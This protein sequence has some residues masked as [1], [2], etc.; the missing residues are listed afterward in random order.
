MKT[1]KWTAGLGVA[2][3]AA[4]CSGGN[5]GDTAPLAVHLKVSGPS[6]SFAA[7]T[8]G[9]TLSSALMV[10]REFELDQTEDADEALDVERGPYLVD[11]TA[12]DFNGTIQQS[13][14][15]TS[16][17]VGVYDEVE[18]EIHKLD[19]S[20][21]DDVAAANAD[22]AGLGAMLSAGLS[23]KIAGMSSAGTQFVFESSLNE[24]QE[25]AVNVV[26]GDAVS[27]IDGVTLTIDPQIWFRHPDTGACLDPLDAANHGTIE[28]N[29]KDSID[30][31]EDDDGDGIPDAIDSDP[32]P[33]PTPNDNA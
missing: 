28:Q 27:G 3:L 30:L 18:Y 20:D 25:K 5:G 13:L 24:T 29:I 26:V 6:S 8:C 11:I 22:P 4:A 33:T 9:N 14:I 17:P 2:A 21:P 7:D 12:A 1:M 19:D 16:L 15:Q 10:I 31:D 23:V 32:D